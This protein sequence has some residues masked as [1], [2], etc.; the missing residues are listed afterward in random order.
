MILTDLD[1][2]QF[3]LDVNMIAYM[4]DRKNYREIRT[5]M[6]DVLQVRESIPEI[7]KRIMEEKTK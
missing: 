4:Y 1:G 5:R 2:T 7:M 3:E 6:K